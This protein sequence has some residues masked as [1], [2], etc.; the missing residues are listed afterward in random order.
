M[1]LLHT[2]VPLEMIFGADE[3][4]ADTN[5]QWVEVGGL[6]LQIRPDGNGGGMVTRLLS[7]DPADYLDPRWQPGRRV[8]V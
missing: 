4:E 2:I 8:K 7:T 5:E 6:Q 3:A 1:S